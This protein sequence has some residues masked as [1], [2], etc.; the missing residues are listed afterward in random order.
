MAALRFDLDE[1]RRWSLSYQGGA[2]SVP[3]IRNATLGVWV[4]ETLATL[5]D[6][7]DISVGNRRPPGGESLVIRGRTPSPDPAGAGGIWLEAEFAAWD[8][9]GGAPQGNI[10][11]SVYP[12]R[13]LATIRGLRFLA[14]RNEDLFPGPGPLLAL[15][16]GYHSASPCRVAAVNGDTDATSHAVL[17]LTRTGRGLALAFD[18]RGPGD[19]RLRL[20]AGG[21]E[22][23]SDWLPPRPLRPEGDSA[24]LGIAYL[25][26]GD[27]LA[28]LGAL[29]TPSSTVDR[30]RLAG[31]P[32]PTG[33]SSRNELGGRITEA[34]VIANLDAC[35]ARFDRRHFRY[36]QIDDGYQRA[37]G[38]WDT[39]AK[40]PRGHTWLTDRIHAAGFLAGLWIAPFAVAERSP[41]AVENPGWLLKGADDAP[42]KIDAPDGW[43]GGAVHVLDGAH[44][45]V[46][47]WLYDLS[48]RVV[49][50]WGY[51]CLSIDLLWWA[52]AG[53]THY[54]GLTHA[55][56]YRRGLSAIRD[57]LGTETF[58][59]AG[60]APL[61]H[62]AGVVNGMRIGPDVEASWAGIQP[63]ARVTAL[64]SPWHRAA[65]LNDPGRLVARAPLSL[66]E[67]R[68]W[69][70]I[71]AASGGITLLSD[72]LTQLPV[73]RLAILQ[74]ALPATQTAGRPIGT[75]VHEGEL[76]P[77][78][79]AG[80]VVVPIRAPWRFRTG[81]DPRYAARE[82]DDET[83]ETVP[84]PQIW[85]RAGHADYDGYAWY[86]SRFV[87][88]PAP[89]PVP[90]AMLELGKVDDADETFVNGTAVGQTRDRLAYRRY[91]VPANA[92]NWG[93]EN[94]V[95]VRV[96]DTG[97][98]GGVWSV[99]RD[100]PAGTWI[101]EGAPRWWTV[102]LVN[103]GDEPQTVQ[104]PLAAL[105]ISGAARF[106]AYDVWRE[107][108]RADVTNTIDASVAPHSCLAIA[109]RPAL[110]RPQVVG[111]TRHVVQ[112]S[113]DLAD[114]RWTATGRT[115]SAKAINLDGRPYAVTVAVPR[116]LRPGACTADVPCTVRRLESG[117]AVIEWPAGTTGDVSW[118]LGFRAASSRPAPR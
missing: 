4:G 60:G 65:W 88:P 85:E 44:P 13:L 72:D 87:L 112:G 113:I 57:G 43:N 89:A 27:G 64:R 63:A 47:R 50:D 106:A 6:L 49:R 30:E 14:T 73:E 81:D 77:A 102:I 37:A 42:L 59:L 61:Q 23:T 28:G 40:F 114:E 116:A 48:R 78:L 2:E 51:D 26:D 92:L 36:F 97:G 105:G 100:R 107:L 84:V 117:H 62:A 98:A 76:A 103:W 7:E 79:V 39:N 118:T 93:G 70:S 11:V 46:Q 9:A 95:A 66:D 90:P 20:T 38:D 54:G 22:A 5:A 17:A 104:Q 67:A 91:A 19:G 115:L 109:L 53:T 12:D 25:P 3:L 31:L 99:R 35:A 69:T 34:S 41:V 86:R 18:A 33:W 15:V 75:Q 110:T 58:L 21:I 55:E 80:D 52:T 108:P 29:T 83:W 24:S 56:A 82:Y 101:V 10:T 96:T 1:Q 94:V 74:K 71:V 32:P 16:N 111:T 8:T 45:D 68:V